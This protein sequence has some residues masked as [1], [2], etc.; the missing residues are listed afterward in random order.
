VPSGTYPQKKLFPFCHTLFIKC[1]LVVQGGFA[2]V[3]QVCIYHA[4]IKLIPAP[5]YLLILYDHASLIFNSLFAT[6]YIIIIYRW[7]ISIFFILS[8]FLNSPTSHSPLRWN[9]LI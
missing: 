9:S 8:H 6:H 1:L 2:L 7:V 5:Y 3:L 4:L